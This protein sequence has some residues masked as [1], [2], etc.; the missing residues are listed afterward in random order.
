[1]VDGQGQN[2]RANRAAFTITKPLENPWL[3]TKEFDY[4]AGT[5]EEGYGTNNDRS[6]SHRRQI[7]FVKPK[8]APVGKPLELESPPMAW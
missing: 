3:S 7:M 1:M 6:V 4:T 8:T 2:R 5:Y